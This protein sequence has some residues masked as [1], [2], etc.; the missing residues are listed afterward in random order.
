MSKPL[1]E[2]QNLL[3]R[4]KHVRWQNCDADSDVEDEILDDMDGVW[5]QLTTEERNLLKSE[6]QG[7]SDKL[8]VLETKCVRR[9]VDVPKDI[10]ADELTTHPSRRYLED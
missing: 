4:L 2:Y 7:H 6:S 9:L 10:R 5:Y 8:A 1:E 3:Q